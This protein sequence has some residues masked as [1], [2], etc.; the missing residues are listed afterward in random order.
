MQM[1]G[2]SRYFS[3]G[4]RYRRRFDSLEYRCIPRTAG[5]NLGEIHQNMAEEKKKRT[6]PPPKENHVENFSGL[7][8]D[9][10]GRSWIQ[11]PYISTTEI[12]P[13]ESGPLFFCK[14]KFC[15]GAGRCMVSL[16]QHGSSKYLVL[17]GFFGRERAG[18][19][20]C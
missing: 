15:T 12:F 20:P 4:S 18:T 5:D 19:R 6:Q 9:F 8:E 14:E 16:P 10:P 7:K 2:V 11:K 13:L 3:K 17:K 1:G